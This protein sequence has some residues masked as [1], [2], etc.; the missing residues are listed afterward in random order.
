M[1]KRIY[2]FD[3]LKFILIL[4]VVIGHFIE[5]FVSTIDVA[6][7]I[8][9][10]IYSFHMPLFIFTTGL[11]IKDYKKYDKLPINKILFYLVIILFMKIYITFISYFFHMKV[12]FAL[13][14]GSGVY[15]Y[16]GT[17]IIYTLLIP[18]INRFNL[19]T[20]ILISFVLAIVA[21]YDNNIGDFLY[22]SRTIVYFPFFLLGYYYSNK[23]ED[24]LNITS[25]KL[26]KVA[27]LLVIIGLICLCIF[28]VDNIYNLRMLFTGKNSF[29][30]V[31]EFYGYTCTYKHRIIAD[32]IALYV[33][34]S[35]MC[36][37]PNKKIRFIT[38]KG[39][40]TL[41]VYVLHRM[42]MLL[43]SGT[44]IS[45]FLFKQF[46]DYSIYIQILIAIIVT[47]ILSLDII[48]KLFDYSYKLLFNE[49]K[50]LS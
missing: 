8:F 21:G 45:S 42:F 11:F 34:F 28:K 20:L 29:K 33:G 12:G 40:K 15:W 10:F 41:Y 30:T 13:F 4:L 9:I 14:S 43:M 17:I 2:K 19:K 37:T 7:K 25:S 5:P 38:D 22:L 18:L 3:N 31:T 36:L 26:L 32:L 50:S 39:S 47:I 1:T 49:K 44:G 24:L 6:K 35:V 16:L 48:K 23:K 46:G 27:S